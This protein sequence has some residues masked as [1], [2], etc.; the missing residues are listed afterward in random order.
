MAGSYFSFLNAKNAPRNVRGTLIPV[1]MS[2]VCTN[3]CVCATS[4]VEEMTYRTKVRVE[5][6]SIRTVLH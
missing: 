4:K 1:I 2:Y 5:Q 3:V 6:T